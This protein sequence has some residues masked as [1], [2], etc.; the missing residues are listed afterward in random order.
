MIMMVFERR[1]KKKGPDMCQVNFELNYFF[2][3]F[4]YG[5]YDRTKAVHS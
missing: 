3:N 2:Y 5:N 4:K 1:L